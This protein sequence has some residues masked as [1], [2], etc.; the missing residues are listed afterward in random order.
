VSK[1]PPAFQF[2]PRDFLADSR[3]AMMTYEEIGIYTVL[4]CHAWTEGGIPSEPVQLARLLKLS[5]QKL[6]R[7][8]SA[9][10]PCWEERDGV[11]V[12][13]RMEQV[14]DQQEEFRAQRRRAGL[15]S[16]EARRKGG[17][18]STS[19]AT[20]VA[21]SLGLCWP[22]RSNG[23]PTLLLHTATA[24]VCRSFEGTTTPPLAERA[25]APTTERRR[26]F[27]EGGGAR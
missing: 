25:A 24:S 26:G 16:A 5:P 27:F 19:V 7:V 18:G 9:I 2:Y 22:S 13:P 15:A 10:G 11:L 1:A 8:W 21:I 20:L 23:E 6:R 12:Q 3:V 17:P 14:R 4:L